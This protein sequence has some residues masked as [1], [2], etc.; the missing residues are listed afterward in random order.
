MILYPVGC[1]EMV[2]EIRY[3]LCKPVEVRQ[4]HYECNK[5]NSIESNLCGFAKMNKVIL[6]HTLRF[7]VKKLLTVFQRI[8]NVVIR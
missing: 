1:V 6:F 4:Q 2:A 8:E 3:C 5:P 7:Q